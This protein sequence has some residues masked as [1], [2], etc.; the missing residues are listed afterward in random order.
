[1]SVGQMRAL[2]RLLEDDDEL[3]FEEVRKRIVELGGLA[4]PYLEEAS[5][6]GERLIRE[7]AADILD[8]KGRL[9]A[10]DQFLLLCQRQGEDLDLEA[11]A[12]A[13]A[14]TRYPKANVEAYRA[15]L[16]SYARDL[17]ELMPAPR[18]SAQAVLAGFNKLLFEQLDFSG[19]EKNYYDPDNSYLNRVL[20]R[21]TGNPIS[22]CQVYLFLARR[23][24][25]PLVGIGMPGHFLCRYQTPTEEY[26]VDPFNQGRLL[27]KADCVKYLNGTASGY[28]ESFLA[29]SSPRRM[30]A[31][32]C[33]N[34][35]QSY[36]EAEDIEAAARVQLYLM[37]LNK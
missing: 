7:R 24:G 6:S 23:L 9:L 33:A 1:M 37:A 36:M 16:D 29:P 13:L 22:L 27:T 35:H 15:L 26:Y 2:V 34:L 12:W 17:A 30:L 18:D 5:T 14:L 10:H 31:R 25:L 21:K 28:H 19:N 11:A 8:G 4:V 32:V 3:V 20:D